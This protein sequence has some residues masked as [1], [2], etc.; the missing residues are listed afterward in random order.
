MI[1]EKPEETGADEKVRARDTGLLFGCRCWL[2]W[3][4][5]CMFVC[6]CLCVCVRLCVCVCVS[7]HAC[8]FICNINICEQWIGFS[9]GCILC[10]FLKCRLFF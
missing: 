6:V 7:V 2:F 10:A 3:Y 5:V 9:F 8:P 1:Q 4:V